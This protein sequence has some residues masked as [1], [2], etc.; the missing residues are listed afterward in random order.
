MITGKEDLLQSL[1]EAFLMEKGTREFYTDAALKALNPDAGKMFRDLSE[2]E[3]KHMGFIQS[4]Y[5]AVQDDRDV[6][7][8]EDYAK[9]TAAPDTEAGIPVKD[10]EE[11]LEKH[12]FIDDMGA[13]VLAL[14]IEGKAYGLYR[15]M[16]ER[17]ADGN[18][19]AVFREMMEQEQKHVEYLKE[20][21]KRLAETS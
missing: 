1:M 21:R 5:L 10:L 2:W 13:L 18:A 15:R 8:F 14:E 9:K 16:S 12:E 4:L 6:E 19:K 3:D 7:R 20:I 11:S 17:A